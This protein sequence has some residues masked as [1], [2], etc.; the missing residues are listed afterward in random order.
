MGS[1]SFPG[2]IAILR[3]PRPGDMNCDGRLDG[4]DID[5]FFLA[6][7]DPAAY[8]LQFPNCD[9]LLGD[10]NADGRLDGGDIDPFFQCLGGGGCP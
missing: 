9:P 10:M 8:L 2:G 3:V 6:L 4:A 7:G 5:P 1:P